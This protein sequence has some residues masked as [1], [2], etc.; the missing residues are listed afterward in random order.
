MNLKSDS[1]IGLHSLQ[2]NKANLNIITIMR[3]NTTLKDG[4]WEKKTEP[5]RIPRQIKKE[6]SLDDQ[7]CDEG[8]NP[9]LGGF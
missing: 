4:G 6:D 8:S 9:L 7:N 3:H 2:I 5:R 1:E